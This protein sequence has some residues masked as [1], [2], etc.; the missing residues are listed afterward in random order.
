MTFGVAL[1]D[2]PGTTSPSPFQTNLSQIKQQDI[3]KFKRFNVISPNTSL[4]LSQDFSSSKDLLKSHTN[5]PVNSFAMSRRE[6][7][8][9]IS[10][11]D[12][13]SMNHTTISNMSSTKENGRKE[14]TTPLKSSIKTGSNGKQAAAESFSQPVPSGIHVT[15]GTALSSSKKRSTDPVPWDSLPSNLM[16]PGKVFESLHLFIV[17][18][19]FSIKFIFNSLINYSVLWKIKGLLRRK[20]MAL[21]VAAEAQ[22]EATSAS[23]IIKGLKLVYCY[24]C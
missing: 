6:R 10:R 24:I 17:N 23:A 21:L 5:S 18:P 7:L 14:S 22:R 19:S 20:N 4:N 9:D 8:K 16:K 1:Q 15:N 2:R 12:S 11:N 13:P 3:S